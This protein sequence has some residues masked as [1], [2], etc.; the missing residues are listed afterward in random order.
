MKDER[1]S[2]RCTN[3]KCKGC[4]KIDG[5]VSA[6]VEV[7][8]NHCHDGDEKLTQ[9]KEIRVQVKR[10]AQEDISSRPSKLF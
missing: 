4:V 7:K 10:K 5:N 9:R 2:W 8:D 6:V 1:V 3:K